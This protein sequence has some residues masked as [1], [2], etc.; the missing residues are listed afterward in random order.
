MADTLV[1]D[2]AKRAEGDQRISTEGSKGNFGVQRAPFTGTIRA[3][4][5]GVH[6]EQ[7]GQIH[8]PVSEEGE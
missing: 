4:A 6:F 1:G 7:S 8:T 2:P 3:W 5:F